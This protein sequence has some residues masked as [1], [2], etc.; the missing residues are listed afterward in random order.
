MLSVMLFVSSCVTVLQLLQQ[1]KQLSWLCCGGSWHCVLQTRNDVDDDDISFS[2]HTYLCFNDHF[3][4][5][6]WASWICRV[7]LLPVVLTAVSCESQIPHYMQCISE[8]E[9]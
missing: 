5:R 3:P 4:G 1:F 6:L 2:C 7:F 8:I 9:N